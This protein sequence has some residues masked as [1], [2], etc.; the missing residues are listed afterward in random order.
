VP[1]EL[2][3]RAK[4]P[5]LPGIALNAG[6]L[7]RLRVVDVALFYGERSGGIRT[8]LEA[9]ANWARATGAIDHH[10]IVPGR[11][12]ASRGGRHEL[13]SLRVAASNGYRMPLGGSELQDLLR[14]LRADVVLLHDPYWT[15]Q[16]TTRAA[17]A[18]GS[19]VVAVHHSSVAMHAVGLP[20]A[21]WM[22]RRGLRRW[23]RR[24]YAEV[25]A[26]MSVVDT[27]DDSGRA[28]SLPLRLGLNSAF[29]PQPAVERGDH[30]LYAGR[31]AR[32]KG[33]GV[34][35]EAAAAS[36]KPWPLVLRGTGPAG[37]ALRQQAKRLGIEHRVRFAPYIG[38]PQDLARAYAQAACVVMPGGHETF[39]FVA[40]EAAACGAPAVA[41]VTAP[42]AR[43]AGPLVERF[44]PGDAR[45]LQRAIERARRR[46]PDHA[47]ASALAARHGWTAALHAELA[48]LQALVGRPALVEAA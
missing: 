33:V 29:R 30:V 7:P 44:R 28:A 25:D 9:K 12:R 36:A 45:D 24:A 26:V 42:A 15:P 2:A 41:A 13:P 19:L 46:K 22:W 11:R 40:L 5:A 31:L 4:R 37:G 1:P 20:G 34:L 32:E 38:R 35:L 43:L 6:R 8:Y 21:P 48:D 14:E 47:A 27:R 3:A 23:Y 10:L 16:G 18:A 17:H 39:G